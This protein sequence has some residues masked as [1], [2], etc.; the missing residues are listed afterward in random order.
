LPATGSI[1]V[2]LRIKD[3]PELPANQRLSTRDIVVTADYFHTAGIPVLRAGRSP[4]WITP[5]DTT[6]S[7]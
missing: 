7:L 3:Q 4:K 1:S 5:P 2:T 6:S